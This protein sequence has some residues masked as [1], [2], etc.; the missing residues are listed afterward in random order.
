MDVL[1]QDRREGL[2]R[3]AESRVGLL[4]L[5]V[6][7]GVFLLSS[8]YSAEASVFRK[9]R[10]TVIDAAAPI[11]KVFAGPIAY[12]QHV[13]GDVGDYFH[14]LKQNEALR[15]ENA[16]LR[17]WMNEALALRKTVENYEQLQHYY[18]PPDAKPINAFVIGE[19]NDSFTHSMLVNVGSKSGVEQGQAV[20]DSGGLVGRI[21][22]VGRRASRILLLTDVQSRVPVYI[23]GAGVEGILVGRTGSKPAVSFVES[24]DPATFKLG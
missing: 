18:A 24:S 4:L 21:V 1:G 19:S 5:I 6:V 12:V 3:K 15:E 13:V 23:E 9:A 8:L 17:Q 11:L 20:V 2:G 22:D 16:E 7:S 14:V 10:E